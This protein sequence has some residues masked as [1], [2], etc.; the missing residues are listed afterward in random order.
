[1]TIITISLPDEL[2]NFIE[3]EVESGEFESKGQVVKKALKKFEED[4]VIGRILL[5][6]KEARE[7]KILR[8]DLKKL[9]KLI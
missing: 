9:S 8:G 3:R 1:M 7:G 6:S 5:A 4:T 2:N